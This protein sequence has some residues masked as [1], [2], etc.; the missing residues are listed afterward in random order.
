MKVTKKKKTK[1]EKADAEKIA[2][3]SKPI[4]K[5]GDKI[6]ALKEKHKNKRSRSQL[7]N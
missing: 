3:A 6:R 5:R 7:Y 2:I 1:E 4:A